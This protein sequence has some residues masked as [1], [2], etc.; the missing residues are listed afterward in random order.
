VKI[1]AGVLHY[2]SWPGVRDT[3]DAL[4]AQTLD[5]DELVL[6]DH[7][8][9]D[10]SAE[11]IRDAYPDLEVIEVSEN[12]GPA[13]GMNLVMRTLLTRGVDGI[14]VLPDDCRL[15]PDALEHLTARLRED[16]TLGAVGPLI[17][18]QNEPDRLFYAGGYLDSRTWGFRL[19]QLPA[20]LSDWEGKP[21]HAVHWL[22][23]FLARA[24]AVRET[25]PMHEGFYYWGDD[26]D[27]TLRMRSLGWRLECVPAAVAW[28]D[29]G[30]P[31]SE[32]LVTRNTLGFLARNAPR[33]YLVRELMRVAYYLIRS[34]VRPQHPSQRS[35]V[36]PRTRGLVDF[37]LGRWGP[38]P[39]SLE[40]R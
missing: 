31:S 29:L 37:C 16:P 22:E 17:G 7:A 24:A 23:L 33:K 25:G 14:L 15:A 1:A 6:I 13:V 36:W 12:R 40:H 5:P 18:Q 38:P 35:E 21:P 28:Q 26:C 10:G 3:L 20:A 8:S 27:Y 30:Y 4:L 32:Y 11:K 39:A 9:N 19:R 34:I 2:R